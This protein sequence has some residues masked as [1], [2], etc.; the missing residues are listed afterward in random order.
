MDNPLKKFMNDEDANMVLQ[1][2]GVLIAL[3][4]LVA[5]G[6][7]LASEFT[8]A[9][10][11]PA[12]NAFNVSTTTATYFPIVVTIAFIACL[13]LIGIPVVGMVLAYFGASGKR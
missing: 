1:G 12:G 3:I 5:L 9:A 4:C 10:A 2:I 7:L 13:A 6:G 8:T 11:L